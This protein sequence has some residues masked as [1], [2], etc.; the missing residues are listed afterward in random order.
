MHAHDGRAG[1]VARG[2]FFQGHGVGQVTGI[3]SAPLLR[4]Q[5]AE[6]AQLAHLGDG[7][8]GETVF[9]VPLGGERFQPFLGKVP[10]RVAYLLLFVIGD[11]DDSLKMYDCNPVG[12]S[13]LAMDVNDNEAA[14]FN[15]VP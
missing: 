9:T 1:T 13:L 10:G 12:A 8:L 2:D 5:H 15:A 14:W 4:H 6:E 7:F 11:H 3:A